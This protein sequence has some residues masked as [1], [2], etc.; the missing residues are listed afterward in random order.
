FDV[1][2]EM[3]G[4]QAAL[5]QMVEAQPVLVRISAAKRLRDAAE[6]LA[7]QNGL[8]RVTR[9]CLEPGMVGATQEGVDA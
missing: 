5:D 6:R 1:G 9:D 8:E 3:T 4:S 2:L 7:R